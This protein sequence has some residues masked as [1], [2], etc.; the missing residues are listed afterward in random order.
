MTYSIKINSADKLYI[1]E[2]GETI[3]S[4]AFDIV[5]EAGVAASSQRHGYPLDTDA[6]AVKADLKNVLD[7]F[8]SDKEQAERNAVSEAA[9]AKADE[10]IAAIV[11]ADITN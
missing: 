8:V 1:Q 9:Q 6:A 5:D 7:A 10:T 11:G 2:S 3:L 4:V